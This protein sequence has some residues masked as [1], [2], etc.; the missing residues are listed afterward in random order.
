MAQR[1]YIYTR[2][3]SH[4]K[5]VSFAQITH[6]TQIH[7][8]LCGLVSAICNTLLMSYMVPYLMK[9][10]KLLV[11]RDS[12]HINGLGFQPVEKW[13]TMPKMG[14]VI[15]TGYNVVLVQLSTEGSWTFFPLR[16]SYPTYERNVRLINIEFVNHNHRVQVIKLFSI[17]KVVFIMKIQPYT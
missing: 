9:V 5:K 16:G 3:Q 15:V 10:F 1:G 7:K 6:K 2:F 11:I 14:Y 13:M 8:M 17:F 12:L 4:S